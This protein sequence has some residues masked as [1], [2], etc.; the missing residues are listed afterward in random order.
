MN[1]NFIYDWG[2]TVRVVTTAPEELHPGQTCAV[3][4]MRQRE[5]TN[6]YLVEFQ[7]GDSFEIPENNLEAMTEE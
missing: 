2:E 6:L 4:G 7:N 5:G 3:C 1:P